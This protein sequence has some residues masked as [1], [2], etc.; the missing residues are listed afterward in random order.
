MTDKEKKL[1]KILTHNILGRLIF[2]LVMFILFQ[3]TF[4][5]GRFPIE[6]IEIMV[7]IRREA[8]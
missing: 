5:L 7:D 3:A 8:L 6:L 2:F 4:Y 1:D